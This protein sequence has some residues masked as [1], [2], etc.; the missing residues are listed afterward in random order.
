MRLFQRYP[1]I[2]QGQIGLKHDSATVQLHYLN[3]SLKI[4]Q[5]ILVEQP[6]TH[7]VDGILRWSA[8]FLKMTK[9]MS[10]EKQEVAYNRTI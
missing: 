4:C 6:K 3:G 5:R 8:P 2:I 9:S 10:I 1:G 7:L